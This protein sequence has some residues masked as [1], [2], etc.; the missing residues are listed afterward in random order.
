[1]RPTLDPGFYWL[2]GRGDLAIYSDV[3][4]YIGQLVYFVKVTKAGLVQVRGWDGKF[5]SVPRRNLERY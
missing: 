4:G 3:K 1:M 5:V 2:S